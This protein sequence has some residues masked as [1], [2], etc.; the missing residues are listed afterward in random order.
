MKRLLLLFTLCISVLLVNC[1]DD[2]GPVIEEV[3]GTVFQGTASNGFEACGWLI[4][5]N[6]EPFLPNVLNSQF[7]QEGLSVFMKV[8]FLEERSICSTAN[9]DPKRLRIEQIRVTN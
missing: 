2:D 8:E 9:I 6:G 1:G 4:D 7:Q 5:I 3:L